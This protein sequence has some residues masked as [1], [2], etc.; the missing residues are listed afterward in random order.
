MLR[1]VWLPI[2][3]SA[4]LIC[5]TGRAVDR[6]WNVLGPATT[7]YETAGNWTPNGTPSDLD[8]VTFPLDGDVDVVLG[9]NSESDN[10]TVSDGIIEFIGFGSA[11]LT[12]SGAVL[13]DDPA[14]GSLPA[15]T[16]VT[17]NGTNEVDWTV[18][19][20]LTVGDVGFGTFTVN[21]GAEMY[22]NTFVTLGDDL[23]SEG[24]MNV[25]GDDSFF[26]LSSGVTTLGSLGAGTV[27]IDGGGYFDG[28]QIV[29]GNE[30]SA[31]G[32]INVDGVG[33]SIAS[34]LNATRIDLG[35]VDENG[36]GGEINVSG[37]A[38][39]NAGLVHVA[40]G[41]DSTG[42]I[43]ITG[44]GS[45]FLAS[46]DFYLGNRGAATMTIDGGSYI[47][48]GVNAFLYVGRM[49]GSTGDMTIQ[50]GGSAHSERT[51][52]IGLQDGSEGT[53][54][55][56]GGTFTVGVL[57]ETT[58][59][60]IVGGG[61]LG[62]M[63][64]INGGS[65]EVEDD[66]W[67]GS[68]ATSN[69]ANQITVT[70]T[71]SSMTVDDQMRIGNDGNGSMGILAG[72]TV[73]SSLT[74]I[75]TF[76]GSVSD[77]VVDGENSLWNIVPS[78]TSEAWLLVGNEGTGALSI[79]NG[80]RVQAV[81]LY[82]GDSGTGDGTLTVDGMTGGGTP[83]TLDISSVD[84][85]VGGSDNE[86]GGT[87]TLSITGGGLVN[88]QAGVIGS[89]LVSGAGGDGTVNVTGT[90]SYW[91]AKANGNG[92]LY[93]GDTGAG[94]LNVTSGGRV[95]TAAMIV[96]DNAGS[97]DATV[98]ID[99]SGGAS[100]VNVDSG[101]IVGNNRPGGLSIINGG[102]LNTGP[103]SAQN[104]DIG[105]DG[106]ADGSWIT[107][108]GQGSTWN[109]MN[110]G[111]M[112]VGV[113]GGTVGDPS[114]L[115]ISG[116]GAVNVAGSFWINDGAA[117]GYGRATITGDDGAGGASTLTVDE[118]AIIA[119]NDDGRLDIEAGGVMDVAGVVDLGGAT[120]D[121]EVYVTGAGSL[122]QSGAQLAVARSNT[123]D[124]FIR[125]GG[126]VA[127]SGNIVI[128]ETSGSNGETIVE[129]LDTGDGSGGSN[130]NTSMS[131][132][133]GGNPSA[134]GGTG[135]LTV[136]SGGTVNVTDTLKVWNTGTVTL[137]GG[138]I[139]MAALDV[140]SSPDFVFNT[141]TVHFTGA[142]VLD[143]AALDDIFA[144]AVVPTLGA[145]QHVAVS[146]AAT[147]DAPLR[148][149]DTTAS[150]SVGSIGDL[151]NLDFD[152]G[153][154]R[155]TASDLTVGVAGVFGESLIVDQQQVVEVPSNMTI[156][157]ADADLNIIRGG[158]SAASAT[159]NGLI[160]VSKTDAVD[161]DADNTGAGL[162]NNGDLI[163][164][165]STIN[166]ATS[167]VASL[168][169][170]GTATF[171]DD[172][173]LG[174]T[175]SLQLGI[176][177]LGDFDAVDVVGV[178]T[179]DGELDL[180]IDAAFA[181]MVGDS[182]T[183]MTYGSYTGEFDDILGSDLGDGSYLRP[184]YDPSQLRLEVTYFGDGNLDGMVDGL[185]Y[186]TWAANFGDSP[187]DDP[188]G[189]P[190]NGDFNDDG[191]VDGLDYLVW[192]GNFGAGSATAVPEPASWLLLALGGVWLIG[193][194]R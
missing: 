8:S 11:T 126:T 176:N 128:G 92:T 104:A 43:T 118:F 66:V 160:I 70:G 41:T 148:L 75:A 113:A 194:R 95:D 31:Y 97:E 159:N 152:A 169:V 22:M 108:D 186:L 80:G 135:I 141:G 45:M 172:L 139:N 53:V 145:D 44:G 42:D 60:L 86:N 150:F 32:T 123:T 72:A 52:Q 39:A 102:T 78:S 122:L 115:T 12:S 16:F 109:Y 157:E 14:A 9:A 84:F 183:V 174:D 17:L 162:V 1:H 107:I 191:I 147:L 29:L 25:S 110:T 63:S 181:A 165:D 30:G 36:G 124:L 182:I 82:V 93:V 121:A 117:G 94:E 193:R 26:S 101:F 144:A 190:E 76:D 71:T 68:E 28:D 127:S 119:D 90:G 58:D 81:E 46:D 179:I 130:M 54:V 111:R 47:G 163:V 149:N 171:G 35:D 24:V 178:A 100:V 153:T 187:A 37:G 61:G 15:G 20:G 50:N 69:G 189:S 18:A 51:A 38:L 158:F 67:V 3:L 137:N 89:G 131:M 57:A 99:G 40:G 98:T 59:D 96:G 175:G 177:S 116:G 167:N 151:S 21:N 13:I 188:P 19:D 56:D 103:G 48:T 168:A 170:T 87:G 34:Q 27:N 155:L 2:G 156:V 77:V 192:A 73:T 7:G 129:D 85:E 65:V 88:S 166:G 55:V 140:V 180:T 10:L 143:Q 114:L 105:F 142:A 83:S 5:S 154:F 33:T 23:G 74:N 146:G 106:A 49:D 136:N 184:I 161:F 173:A 125:D 120:G 133:V 6:D 164:I 4:V 64:V 91:N 62:T 79:T 185:D 132:Y 112:R 134:Q 138:T